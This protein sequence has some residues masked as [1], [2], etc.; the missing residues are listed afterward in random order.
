MSE[1]SDAKKRTAEEAWDA[2]EQMSVDDE[3][4]RVLSLSDEELDAELARGGV[5]PDKVRA[6]GEALAARM[7]TSDVQRPE[8]VVRLENT[9]RPDKGRAPASLRV[10]WVAWLAAAAVSGS[11]ATFAVVNANPGLVAHPPPP[12]DA[13]R[14]R[15]D[16]LTACDRHDWARCLELLDQA[17]ELDP[18]GDRSPHIQDARRIAKSP[19]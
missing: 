1:A 17:K 13:A 3:V 8:N 19:R 5:D 16:G 12:P 10:R 11:A 18:E 14:L 7:A 6:R 4:D 2:L 9:K 15:E